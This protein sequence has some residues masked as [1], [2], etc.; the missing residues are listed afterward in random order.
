MSSVL[1]RRFPAYMGGLLLSLAAMVAIMTAK[2]AFA[3]KFHLVQKTYPPDEVKRGGKFKIQ[4]GA[5]PGQY[6][7]PG[8]PTALQLWRL[9]TPDSAV[10]Q[11]AG[12][13]QLTEL[14][15][16]FEV[17]EGVRV[18]GE[19]YIC[20]FPGAAD[21]TLFKF[22]REIHVKENAGSSVSNISIDLPSLAKSGLEF[23][24]SAEIANQ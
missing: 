1:R 5:E 8:F 4:Y 9:S 17:G 22:E 24:K 10:L 16:S 23:G 7:P 18:T 19:I 3:P 12:Y 14:E 15:P 6:L 21:C 13:R 20:A 2:K 11:R